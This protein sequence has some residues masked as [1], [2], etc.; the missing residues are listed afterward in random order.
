MTP[1]R[2]SPHDLHLRALAVYRERATAILAQWDLY[3]TRNPDADSLAYGLR[4]RV[5]DAETWREF[6]RIAPLTDSLLQRAEHQLAQLSGHR[7]Q[8]RWRGQ[9][10]RLDAANR[11]LRQLRHEW[12]QTRTALPHTARPGTEEYD[13]P[14]AERNAD[15][16]GYLDEWTLLSTALTEIDAAARAQSGTP[17][18]ARGLTQAAPAPPAAGAPRRR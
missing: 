17:V 14:I 9:L 4:Q 13:E 10:G 18:T 11:G 16:W 5:R 3:T 6:T 2:S 12:R 1:I 8:R 15:A 7:E